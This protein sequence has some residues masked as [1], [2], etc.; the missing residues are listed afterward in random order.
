[1]VTAT[2]GSRARILRAICNL[3]LFV[4]LG[5]LTFQFVAA[6]P[7]DKEKGQQCSDGQDND[8]DFL[9]DGADPDCQKGG[10]TTSTDT[11]IQYHVQVIT[12]SGA[13]AWSPDPVLCAAYTVPGD[14]SFR[15]RFPRHMQCAPDC[16][17][18]LDLEESLTDDIALNL[19]TRKGK[20]TGFAISGQD[21]IGKEGIMH[22]SDEIPLDLPVPE[23]PE[24]MFVIQIDSDVTIY[25]LSG[26]LAGRRVATA[27]VIHVGSLIYTPCGG[28]F[29]CPPTWPV[30]EPE[31]CP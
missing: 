7:A 16:W 14:T 5:S 8:G 1:M 25:R 19:N 18:P 31:L 30:E 12:G 17:I 4:F 3:A 27:G 20:F 29:S 28:V 21:T 10:D 13:N 2:L 26:H 6:A 15:V 23:D 24:Q 22:E 9:I 11:D